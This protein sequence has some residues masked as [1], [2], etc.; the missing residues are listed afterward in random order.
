MAERALEKKLP[1]ALEEHQGSLREKGHPLDL[2]DQVVSHGVKVSREGAGK[3]GGGFQVEGIYKQS[4]GD[5]T[6]IS[7]SK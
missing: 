1:G 2:K 7:C 4:L 3:G 5:L 6:N